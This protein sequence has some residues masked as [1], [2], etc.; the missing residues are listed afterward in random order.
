MTLTSPSERDQI[1][2]DIRKALSGISLK[3]A[4]KGLERLVRART[5]ES[6]KQPLGFLYTDLLHSP[7]KGRPTSIELLAEIIASWALGIV[8]DLG[9]TQFG[10]TYERVIGKDGKEKR[11]FVIDRRIQKQRRYAARTTIASMNL[12]VTAF[13]L[14]QEYGSHQPETDEPPIIGRKDFEVAMQVIAA[15]G[16][17]HKYICDLN[18]QF[19]ES[20][21]G[22]VSLSK[23]R[24]IEQFVDDPLRACGVSRRK[25]SRIIEK[26]IEGPCIK[27]GHKPRTA[28]SIEQRLPSRTKKNI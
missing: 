4:V 5:R 23:L 10:S 6:D 19:D 8:V 14:S 15:A 25:S 3:R 9:H 13:E 7:T 18:D 26:L 11:R 22:E 24:G 2:K 16:R 1:T 27:W 21:G 28:R 17:W 20:R 12:L